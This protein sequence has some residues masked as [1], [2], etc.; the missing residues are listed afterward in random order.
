MHHVVDL[1]VRA[2]G[3][4]QVINFIHLMSPQSGEEWNSVALFPGRRACCRRPCCPHVNV[5][6]AVYKG[7]TVIVQNAMEVGLSIASKGAVSS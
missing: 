5:Y 6:I 7:E 4:P 1:A 3:G 2:P